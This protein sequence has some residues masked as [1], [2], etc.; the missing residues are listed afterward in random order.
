MSRYQFSF[1]LVPPARCKSSSGGLLDSGKGEY[2]LAM[3]KERLF[4]G[5][6]SRRLRFPEA[7]TVFKEHSA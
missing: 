6:L 2:A 5:Q 1:T 7:S 4:I 3:R